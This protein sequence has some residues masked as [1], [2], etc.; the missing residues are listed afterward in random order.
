MK[1]K[2]NAAVL[3]KQNEPLRIIKLSHN[4]D[5]Q[6]G[7]ILV[8]LISSGICGAQINEIRGLK[9]PDKFLPHMMGHE[10]YGE[11]VKVGPGVT[12][13]RSGDLVVLHWRKGS[14]IDATPAKFDSEIGIVGA[15]PVT[16]FSEYSIVSENRVTQLEQFIDPCS[17]AL[18]GCG[19]TTAFGIVKNEIQIK[20]VKQAMVIGAG[21]LGLN[22]IQAL[23]HHGV[24]N[25]IAVDNQLYKEKLS[26]EVGADDFILCLDGNLIDLIK[27]KLPAS[28]SADLVIDTTGNNLLIGQGFDVLAKSGKLVLVG[29]PKIGT[30]LELNNPLAFFDGKSI[31]ASDGGLTNPDFDIPALANLINDK[32]IKTERIITHK[33][34]LRDIND[35]LEILKSGKSGRIVITHE[36]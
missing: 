5:L 4:S 27:F 1:L 14:G 26:L 32:I 35:G 9:G 21:G 36:Q 31:F 20:N 12:K 19:L 22:I 3:I 17:A 15:G 18:L 8:K 16:T 23:K 11:V 2:F 25:I 30:K 6:V 28:F 7:Q 13:V 29:Q 33:I 10:G 24:T 34:S